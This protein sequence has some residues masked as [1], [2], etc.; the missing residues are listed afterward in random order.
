MLKQF[1]M[2]IGKKTKKGYTQMFGISNSIIES[3]LIDDN[4]DDKLCSF[5]SKRQ[6]KQFH[7][8]AKVRY[9]IE[10]FIF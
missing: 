1:F 2:N 7:E 6:T 5:F 8:G 3:N 10:F 4:S 9:I